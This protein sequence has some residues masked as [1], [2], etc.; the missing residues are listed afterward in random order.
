MNRLPKDPGVLA[1][2]CSGGGEQTS[3]GSDTTSVTSLALLVV[4]PHCTCGQICIGDKP[5]N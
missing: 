3:L 2:L 5:G 1:Y 4:N